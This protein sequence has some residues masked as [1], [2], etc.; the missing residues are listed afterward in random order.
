MKRYTLFDIEKQFPKSSRSHSLQI[1]FESSRS[2]YSVSDELDR[3]R[4][5]GTGSSRKRSLLAIEDQIRA[6]P[7]AGRVQAQVFDFNAPFGEIRQSNHEQE[8]VSSID[9][10]KVWE[11]AI[12]G[13]GMS[14]E[15][16][17]FESL[18]KTSPQTVSEPQVTAAPEIPPVSSPSRPELPQVP[19]QPEYPAEAPDVL[20]DTQAFEEDLKAILNRE[21]PFT[22]K[23][24]T[25]SAKETAPPTEK[26]EDRHAIFDKIAQGLNLSN[27]TTFDMGDVT[28][29]QK[30]DAFDAALDEEEARRE[31]L[32][33]PGK[34]E[35]FSGAAELSHIDLVGDVSEIR[36]MAGDKK[37]VKETVSVQTS[38][39]PK[40]KITYNP[41][42]IPQQEGLS[43]WSACGVMLVAW[44][45]NL[46]VD[47]EQLAQGEGPWKAF[48][49]KLYLEGTQMIETWGLKTEEHK[50]YEVEE[51][52]TLLE[53]HGPLL[54]AAT[55][56]DPHARVLAGLLGDGSSDGTSVRIFDPWEEHMKSFTTPNKGAVYELSFGDFDQWQKGTSSDKDSDRSNGIVIA[57][58]E[59]IRITN[60]NKET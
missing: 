45:D 11:Q 42:L 13:E 39:V 26:Q 18:P 53:K 9:T 8:F 37:P 52:A 19:Q 35:S 57:H 30:F 60:V 40:F 54:I 2:T 5:S 3:L 28:I 20:P 1:T 55:T 24:D 56:S 25:E 31:K 10:S 46:E 22:P 15:M 29:Q 34:I 51:L 38:P 4:G 17:S 12:L 59:T 50:T 44:K 6:T 21:K 23:P 41:P 58:L 47:Q 49:D 7:K 36:A 32:P 33:N 14:Y 43:A 48:K 27:A 16:E